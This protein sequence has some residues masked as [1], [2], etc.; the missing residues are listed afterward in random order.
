M[1]LRAL[2]LLLPALAGS[3]LQA[4][5]TVMKRSL[6]LEGAKRVA[7]AFETSARAR[8]APGAVMAIADEG[9]NLM[10]VERLDG[11]IPAGVEV[12]IGKAK[13]AAGFM[14]PTAEFENAIKNGRLA[15][16]GN[17]IA[18]PLQGGVPLVVEGQ[19]VG[20]IGVSGAASA[21][22]DEEIALDAA[23]ALDPATAAITV[24]PGDK[25]KAA[26]AKGM[27][28]LEVENYKV[29]A[30]HREPGSGYK[31]EVHELDTDII[32]VLSGTAT[33]VTGG[34]LSEARTV[35]PHELRGAGVEGGEARALVPGDVVIVP[36]GTPH[37]FKE[38]PGP[39]NYYVVK[40]AR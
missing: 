37:W 17:R 2:A 15:F 10:Y 25:V 33:F 6:T 35:E 24:V 23:K 9:G 3:A 29:H 38:V 14:R 26:F 21:V 27:P 18:T 28:L 11:T 32:Y 8:K 39:L 1:H 12:C 5:S 34:R 4:Q 20:A 40:V 7:A 16:L 30:S 13:T 36:R 31:S 19:I 22:Q